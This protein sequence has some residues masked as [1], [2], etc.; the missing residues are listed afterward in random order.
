MCARHSAT[1]ACTCWPRSGCWR[2]C[3]A[4]AHSTLTANPHRD[5]CSRRSTGRRC[6]LAALPASCASSL[7]C[8]ASAAHLCL[9]I[10][11]SALRQGHNRAQRI[12]SFALLRILADRVPCWNSRAL[13]LQATLRAPWRR[14]GPKQCTCFS[15]QAICCCTL[16]NWLPVVDAR[17][18]APRLHVFLILHSHT[19]FAR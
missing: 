7:Q 12:D 14:S 13:P 9:D 15:V 3:C 5:S 4:P 18:G 8:I 17:A 2:R 6:G 10:E 19:Q 1:P 11:V 16:S